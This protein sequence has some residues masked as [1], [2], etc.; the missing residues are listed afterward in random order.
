MILNILAYR[1]YMNVLMRNQLNY[2]QQGQICPISEDIS[3]RILCLPLSH[4]LEEKDQN[5][6]INTIMD[7]L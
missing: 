1:D 4:A 7:I 3:N 2:V 6:I 5:I